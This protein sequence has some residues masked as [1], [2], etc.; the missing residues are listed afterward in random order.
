MQSGLPHEYFDAVCM[1]FAVRAARQSVDEDERPHPRVGVVVAKEGEI[2]AVA[3]RGETG[4]GDHAE[5]AGLEK[6]LADDIV[7]GATV[8]TTLEPCTSRNHP[9]VPCVQRL[10]DR[11]VARVVIGMVDPDPNIRGEGIRRLERARV[12][13]D[14]FPLSLVEELLD[15]NRHFIR[16][17]ESLPEPAEPKASS[18]FGELDESIDL[19]GVWY[20][21][22]RN[23][24]GR[25]GEE[26]I[27][28]LRREGSTF[29]GSFFDK[30]APEAPIVFEGTLRKPYLRVQYHAPYSTSEG[31]G[32]MEDGSCFLN[33]Q[34]DGSFKGFYAGFDN[35]GEYELRRDHGIAQNPAAPTDQKALLPGR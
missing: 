16:A 28:V 24:D 4:A 35:Y 13:V 2:L 34:A 32:I 11:R 6:K 14:K 25:A 21:I 20:G 31:K 12:A 30:S 17:K 19:L 10:I 27:H 26:V 29:I 22:W 8:Y 3:H 7:A 33:L 1:R 18:S 5:F 23:P 9:K 15:L